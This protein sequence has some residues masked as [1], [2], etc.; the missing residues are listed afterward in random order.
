MVDTLLDTPTASSDENRST[1]VAEAVSPLQELKQQLVALRQRAQAAV[2][3]VTEYLRQLRSSGAEAAL[4]LDVAQHLAET[5]ENLS[6]RQD[7]FEELLHESFRSHLAEPSFPAT[8]SAA[9]PP[10]WAWEFQASVNERLSNLEARLSSA[11]TEPA[12]TTVSPPTEHTSPTSDLG[13][14][15]LV[16][17]LDGDAQPW[18]QVMLGPELSGDARMTSAM[19]WFEQSVMS[20]RE[21]ALGLLGQLLVFR[22]ALT[23]RKPN[24]LKEVGEAFYRCFPKTNDKSNPFEEAL[25][26]W[27]RQHCEAAGLVNSIEVVHPGERFDSAKHA[28]LERGGVE[29]TKVLGWVVVRDN[30]RVY[31]KALVQTR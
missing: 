30:G 17:P 13:Q 15:P 20:G 16:P 28:P 18:L 2:Q 4:P 11:C 6:Q 31:S 7:S 10:P 19:H 25:A 23:D 21:D 14:K 12:A 27:L 24:L 26:A 29:I 8:A 3:R 9:E 5:L 1:L 22:F